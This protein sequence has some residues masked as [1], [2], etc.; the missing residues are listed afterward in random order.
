V[1]LRDMTDDYYMFDEEEYAVVGHRTGRTLTLG[2][3]V[4][5]VVRR[6]DLS[7]KQLDFELVGTID[8]E[9]GEV[10]RFDE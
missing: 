7:R 9:S 10:Y 3:R 8:F 6:A 1:A 4:R 5:I 2:D